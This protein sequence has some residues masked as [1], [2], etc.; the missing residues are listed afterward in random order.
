MDLK[1]VTLAY[2]DKQVVRPDLQKEFTQVIECRS[3]HRLFRDVHIRLWTGFGDMVF[4]CQ[5]HLR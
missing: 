4:F 3:L 1:Q 5:H 2:T